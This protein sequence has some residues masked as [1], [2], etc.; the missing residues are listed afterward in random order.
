MS[1]FG[2]ATPTTGAVIDKYT[3]GEL[4]QRS[5]QVAANPGKRLRPFSWQRS[6]NRKQKYTE[7]SSDRTPCTDN[8]THDKSFSG[9]LQYDFKNRV[10]YFH[11]KMISF[12]EF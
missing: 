9:R 5:N 6:R 11:E 7:E 8:F 2:A 12:E 4:Q 10:S 1:C 3:D